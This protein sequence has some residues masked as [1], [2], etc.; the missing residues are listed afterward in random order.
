LFPEKAAVAGFIRRHKLTEFEK[1]RLGHL[2]NK[3][4]AGKEMI[5]RPI[6]DCLCAVDDEWSLVLGPTMLRNSAD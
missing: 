1:S 2:Y 3:G 5:R 4:S 6:P